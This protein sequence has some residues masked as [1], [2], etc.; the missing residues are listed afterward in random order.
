MFSMRGPGDVQASSAKENPLM[1]KPRPGVQEEARSPL[2]ASNLS[3]VICPLHPGRGM[4]SRPEGSS[5]EVVG[6]LLTN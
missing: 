2:G 6:Y 4:S 1:P 3:S 5:R